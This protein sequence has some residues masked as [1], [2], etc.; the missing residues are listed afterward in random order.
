[1]LKPP[2]IFAAIILCGCV[3]TSEGT[4]INAPG[5]DSDISSRTDVFFGEAVTA[6]WSARPSS[7]VTLTFD[8]ILEMSDA[9]LQKIVSDL[10]ECEVSGAPFDLTNLDGIATMRV[11]ISCSN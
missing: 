3:A 7:T 5:R 2:I 10:T 8:S 11:P 1:M 6:V 9:R 4:Q